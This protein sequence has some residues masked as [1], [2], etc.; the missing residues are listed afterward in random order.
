MST[1]RAGQKAVNIG[2]AQWE[3]EGTATTTTITTGW[4]LWAKTT[5]ITSPN[6]PAAG[7]AKDEIVTIVLV[8]PD[9]HLV[10]SGYEKYGRY[11]PSSFRPLNSIEEAMERI[12]KEAKRDEL[13]QTQ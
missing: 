2:D 10:L 6:K 13:M 1:F 5:T 9:G 7:P 12:E 3:F 4:W 8:C 11:D